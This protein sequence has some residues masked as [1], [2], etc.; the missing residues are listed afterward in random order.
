MNTAPLAEFPQQVVASHALV[1]G[2][3]LGGEQLNI[4]TFVQLAAET[5][6][7][8]KLTAL[9]CRSVATIREAR[10]CWQNALECFQASV[11]CWDRLPT[12]GELQ[13]GHRRLL[14]RLKCQADDQLE[15]Y[16]DADGDRSSY[17]R[18]KS[19]K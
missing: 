11:E 1:V 13:Q 9:Q 16:R 10:S 18:R 12:N 19:S 5:L 2:E 6:T 3:I 14:E 15:F 17:R 7:V 8:S 4:E